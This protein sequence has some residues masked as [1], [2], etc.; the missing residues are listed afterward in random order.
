MLSW[1]LTDRK[2]HRPECFLPPWCQFF[3]DLA[4]NK[5][6][7]FNVKVKKLTSFSTDVNIWNI[8]S[9]DSFIKHVCSCIHRI[10]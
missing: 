3:T 5:I 6:I 2:Q 8:L 9:F 10:F 7:S 1:L 4:K